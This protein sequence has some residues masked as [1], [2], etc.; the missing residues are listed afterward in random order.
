MVTLLPKAT[1]ADAGR[2]RI[3]QM[4]D[5]EAPRC[6][7]IVV[8]KV[9]LPS[10]GDRRLARDLGHNVFGY[11]EVRVDLLHVVVLFQGVDQ[12]QG[13]PRRPRVKVDAV[14]GLHGD[15]RILVRDV[16]PTKRLPDGRE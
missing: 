14:L 11:I 2:L 16:G 1:L 4:S 13:L 9:R 3:P 5:S 8:A 10:M 12:T 7:P 15:L 6:A